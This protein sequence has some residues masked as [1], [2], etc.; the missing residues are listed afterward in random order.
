MIVNAYKSLTARAALDY[1]R[2]LGDISGKQFWQ[3]RFYDHIISNEEELLAIRK[4]IRDNPI[5]D[6]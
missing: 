4:Y 3:Q 5:N 2:T 6:L 1:L